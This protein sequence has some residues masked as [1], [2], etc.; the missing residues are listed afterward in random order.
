MKGK[1]IYKILLI[2][3][4]KKWKYES[5][6]NN[7][8]LKSA[9]SHLIKNKILKNVIKNIIKIVRSENKVTDTALGLK[10]KN[11]KGDKIEHNKKW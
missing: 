4:K 6:K 5:K 10:V 3:L 1:W 8:F 9:T 7:F 2:Q 11:S